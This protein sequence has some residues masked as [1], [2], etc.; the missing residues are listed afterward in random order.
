MTIG[1]L[2]P[3]NSPSVR[4]PIVVS[5]T[6]WP[7]RASSATSRASLVATKTLSS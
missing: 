3:Q 2:C 4:S 7:L 1:P 6:V 5:Q